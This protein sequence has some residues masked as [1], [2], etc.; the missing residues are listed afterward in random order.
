MKLSISSPEQIEAYFRRLAKGASVD[1]ADDPT[2]GPTRKNLRRRKIVVE[3]AIRVELP[4]ETA[5]E[6][7]PQCSHDRDRGDEWWCLVEWVKATAKAVATP[8]ERIAINQVL[9]KRSDATMARL[10]GMA[11]SSWQKLR[12][13]LLPAMA[14]RI[15][16]AA[17]HKVDAIGEKY[18]G[19]DWILAASEAEPD[20]LLSREDISDAA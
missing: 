18:L 15:V 17:D 12:E 9:N 8:E 1:A 20:V 3:P 2:Y 13:E 6:G 14:P 5:E 11:K 7:T 10:V 4:D 16:A 19:I